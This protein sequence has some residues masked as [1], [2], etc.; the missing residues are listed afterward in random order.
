[1]FTSKLFY[2]VWFQEDYRRTVIELDEK[3]FISMRLVLCELRNQYVSIRWAECVTD[4]ILL[5]C[6]PGRYN[7]NKYLKSSETVPLH[8]NF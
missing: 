6:Q 2:L 7:L 4:V 3:E 8:K 5:R 1:M